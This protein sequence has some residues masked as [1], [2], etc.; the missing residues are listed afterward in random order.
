MT[1]LGQD[2]LLP[3]HYNGTQINACVTIHGGLEPVCYVDNQGW[4]VIGDPSCPAQIAKASR[5]CQKALCLA[6][7]CLKCMYGPWGGALRHLKNLAL[8]FLA[9][10]MLL[11][12]GCPVQQSQILRIHL[13]ILHNSPQSHN[14]GRNWVH[15]GRPCDG[16]CRCALRLRQQRRAPAQ[17]GRS[18]RHPWWPSPASPASPTGGTHAF[19][20]PLSM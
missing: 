3:L 9:T 4:Q 7:G 13:A 5:A 12:A 17:Q 10:P 18:C 11:N 20:P 16:L 14:M 2:C 6:W 8:H 1:T 19:C 15:A